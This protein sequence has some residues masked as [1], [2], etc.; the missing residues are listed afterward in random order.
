MLQKLVAKISGVQC[1]QH[2][3]LVSIDCH[4]HR[5]MAS[6]ARQKKE[7]GYVR[8]KATR[9]VEALT[10]ALPNSI[11]TADVMDIN[12]KLSHHGSHD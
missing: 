3:F 4:L 2:K 12:A 7:T 10:G 8:M 5:I 6:L 1:V 11:L 9:R